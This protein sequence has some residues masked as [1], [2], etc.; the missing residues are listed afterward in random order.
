MCR[1]GRIMVEHAEA[2]LW[3]HVWL[4]GSHV[5]YTQLRYPISHFPPNL[6]APDTRMKD[7]FTVAHHVTFRCL[8]GQSTTAHQDALN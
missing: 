3:L 1:V 8:E 7:R 4:F 5:A 6:T 2:F